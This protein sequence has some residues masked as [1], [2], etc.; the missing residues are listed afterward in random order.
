[1]ETL[2]KPNLFGPAPGGQGKPFP[3][4]GAVFASLMVLLLAG[5]LYF[6]HLTD[7]S[8]PLTTPAMQ[9]ENPPTVHNTASNTP[10]T[11]PAVGSTANI[12]DHAMFAP[13]ASQQADATPVIFK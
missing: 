12:A 7:F 6:T 2:A 3:F 11:G 4:F 10:V 13:L 8:S 1:M 9:V 5:I